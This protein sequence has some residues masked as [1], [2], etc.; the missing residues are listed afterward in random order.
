MLSEKIKTVPYSF[1]RFLYV[2]IWIIFF[3][4]GIIFL[5]PDFGWHL[6]IGQEILAHGIPQTDLFSYTMP[7]YP[8]VDSEWLTDVLTAWFYPFAGKIGLS[9]V[10][11]A[12]ATLALVLVVPKNFARWVYLPLILSA[13]ILLE[14]FG[15]RPQIISWFFLAVLLKIILTPKIWEKWG[16]ALPLIFVFWANLHGG[17]AA[18]IVVLSCYLLFKNFKKLSLN[19][20]RIWFFSLLATLLNPYGLRLW[21]EV[22]RTFSDGFLRRAIVEWQPGL[23]RFDPALIIFL[24]LSTVLVFRVRKVWGRGQ[25]GLYLTLFAAGLVSSRNLPFW[26]LLSLPMMI[27]GSEYFYLEAAKN[28]ESKKRF[29]SVL[30]YFSLAVIFVSFF[31]T[32]LIILG[33]GKSTEERYYPAKAVSFLKSHKVR[34]EI[35]APYEWGGYLDLKLPEKKVF[36]DGRMPIWRWQAPNKSESAYAFGEYQKIIGGGDFREAFE[37]YKV[38]MVLWHTLGSSRQKAQITRPEFLEKPDKILGNKG[39]PESFNARLKEAG[40]RKI[41]ADGIAE[42]YER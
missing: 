6:R 33:D 25:L 1:L 37:K 18:G 9:S 27:L 11:A 35:F 12:L 16:F 8:F 7:S 26:F 14:Y 28:R 38:K 23:S 22:W 29:D 24:A 34:G 32:A 36:I 13:T 20:L 5:D 40:W 31:Q 4:D 19:D 42:I 10:Y 3:I 21:G 39:S 2:L 15:V 30:R 17:F 41:Y